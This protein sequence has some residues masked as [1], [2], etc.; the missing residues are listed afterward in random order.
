MDD[1][2]GAGGSGGPARVLLLSAPVGEGH[3]AAARALAARM[4][5]L[6][7][8]AEVLEVESTGR[9]SRDAL[10]R[11][12]YRLTLRFVPRLYGIGY[13]LLVRFPKAAEVFKAMSAGGIGR[14]LEPVIAAASPDLVISTYPMISGGLAWLRRRGRLPGRAVAVV[15]DV[16]VHPFWVWPDLDETWTLLPASREQARAV[17]PLAEVRVVPAAVDRR[18]RPGDPSA[19]RAATGLRTDAFVVLVTG[20]SLGFGGLERVVDAV[21]A[22]GEDVQAVVLCAR[23]ERLR[24]RLLARGLPSDRLVAR[25]WT[26]RVA[27]EITAAD[28][29]VTTAG[30]VIATEALAVG[31]AVLF[32]APIPGHGRAGAAMTAAAGLAVVCRTPAE[33]TAAVR[34]L[35]EDPGARA[36]L[37]ARAAE[38]GRADLD[39]E[40][41]ALALRV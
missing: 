32:A 11:V 40:L 13:D 37:A 24:A 38:F 39:D 4:R 1:A 31:R 33:V 20:G 19:A 28:L 21:L 14:S 17:A 36:A 27:E 22:G 10:L 12:S 15:T 30:G 29:V 6:W 25:G 41:A 3:V 34:R 35:R 23:N 9:G 8:D 18:F 26:D 7:P 5:V 16:A 2:G